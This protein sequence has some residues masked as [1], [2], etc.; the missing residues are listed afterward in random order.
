MEPDKELYQRTFSR[1][2]SSPELR[3][4][5]LS[6]TEKV[7]KPKRFIMRR[8]IVAA[9]VL[10]LICALA[11]GA[12]AATGGELYEHTLGRLVGICETY[13]GIVA[14]LYQGENDEKPCFVI[15]ESRSDAPS[16]GEGYDT[17]GRVYEFDMVTD[18]N[19]SIT[20]NGEPVESPAPEE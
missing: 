14:K 6:M 3:K 5:L 10:A 19:G 17:Y 11:M 16:S 8:L 18:E 7:R 4:E 12:N 15:V 2:K 13:D 9:A 1:L 20:M